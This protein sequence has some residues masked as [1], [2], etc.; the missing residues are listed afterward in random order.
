MTTT[1]QTDPVALLRGLGFRAAT[2]A[3]NAFLTHA[4]AAR[5]SPIQVVEQLA[6][7][8]RQH[9]D[10]I[11]LASR[12]RHATLGKYKLL[13]KFDWNHPTNVSRELYEQL[14]SLEF[15]S[16]GE[17]AL[18]R[19][20][21]G[22]GKTT[23][24][25]NLCHEALRKGMRVRFSTLASMMAELL[26]QESL[27]ALE[28]RMRSYILPHVLVVD[29]LGYMPTDARAADI[30]FNIISRRHLKASTIITTN[31]AYKDWPTIFPGASCLV[32][33]VDRFAENC[34]VMDMDG[35]SYRDLTAQQFRSKT[36]GGKP[37][38]KS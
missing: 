38:K 31:L 5:F 35:E 7:L 33:L 6:V 28:R 8:E 12:T 25:Q 22:I 11:N 15:I 4:T 37:K 30:L 1:P 20:P 19:G 2:D 32:A 26:K 3:L 17:N 36:K 13:D 27:P 24:V 10:A 16:R 23:L 21:C 34:H 14:Q 18:F 9:R 29:E